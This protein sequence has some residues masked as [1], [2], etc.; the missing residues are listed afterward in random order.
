MTT[1]SIYVRFIPKENK[2]K[3]GWNPLEID[4]LRDFLVL[5]ET[6]HFSQAAEQCYIS[7]STLSKRIKKLEK[8]VGV[9]LFTRTTKSVELNTYGELLQEYA[10][11]IVTLEK[12]YFDELSSLIPENKTPFIIGAI[13]SLSKYHL[14]DLVSKFMVE[15]NLEIKIITAPSERLE[16]MLISGACDAAFIRE[17]QDPENQFTRRIIVSDQ[18]MVVL[19]I[20]HNLAKSDSITIQEL[21]NENFILLPEGTRPYNT[22]VQLCVANGFNPTIVFT[23]SKISNIIDFITNG[24]GISLLMS[25]NIDSNYTNLVKTIPLTPPIYQSVE[26]CLITNKTKKGHKE[27]LLEFIDHLDD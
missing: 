19:P 27:K 16:T 18:L 3:K 21:A 7:Q 8:H 25:K 24:M 12:N 10:K 2:P 11:K 9:P 1:L 14:T 6:R 23:D 5:A 13:P 4:L 22:S 17:V 20:N 26:L 15:K